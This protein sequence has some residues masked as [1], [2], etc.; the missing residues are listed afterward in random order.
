MMRTGDS[1]HSHCFLTPCSLL[2]YV[3]VISQEAAG[4]VTCHSFPGE[5]SRGLDG[6][7]AKIKMTSMEAREGG[8][9]GLG[10]SGEC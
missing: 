6:V 3:M 7:G 10:H 8:M 1:A 5:N 9:Q 2:Q 4:D